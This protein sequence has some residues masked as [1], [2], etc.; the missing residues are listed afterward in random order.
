MGVFRNRAYIVLTA[1]AAVAGSQLVALTPASASPSP[2]SGVTFD[3]V[4]ASAPVLAHYTVNQRATTS[5]TRAVSGSRSATSDRALARATAAAKAALSRTHR[6]GARTGENAGDDPRETRRSSFIGMQSSKSICPYFGTGCN[7]PDMAI[8]A[9]PQ[10]VLQGVNSSFEV[11]DTRGH[12]QTGWPRNSQTFFGVPNEPNNCD[13]ASGNQPFMSDPRAFYDPAHKRFWAASLQVEGAIGVAVNCPLLTVY[14][15]AV[16]QTSDPRG[17]WNVYEFDMSAGT[18]NVADFTQFGFNGDAVYFSANMFTQDGTAYA[19]AE[20][21]EANKR[22]MENGSG[23]FTSSG[24]LSLTATGP[25][26]TYLAATVQPV[27]TLGSGSRGEYFVNT[28]DAPDPVNGHLCQ[29]AADTCSGL[30]LWQMID[31]I[32][33]DSGGPQPT[34]TGTYVPTRPYVFAPPADQPTCTQCIDASDLR[35]SD[36]PVYQNGTVHAAWETAIDNRTQTVPGIEYAQVNVAH[37]RA[38]Q[39]SYYRFGGDTAVSFPAVMPDGHGRVVM[40]YD[41]MSSTVNPQTRYVTTE[42]RSARFT[43]PGHLIKAGE[44]PYRPGVCGTA[45]LPVCRWGDYSAASSDGSGNVWLAGQYANGNVGP[46]TDPN[47]SSRNW[48]T[49]IIGL[50]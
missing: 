34:L 18:T 4:R 28:F 27:L 39:S 35:I 14:Y 7:P 47:F 33:H 44:A 23:A 46:S 45:V 3:A 29:N 10:W 11:L 32:A 5:T 1:A 48:G 40:V 15:L 49:W 50:R 24:F 42:S 22:M 17:V 30:G 43:G 12:V 38:S 41:L 6:A 20:L 25:G 36:T 8:A 26:A 13:P 2:T 9:S 19:Y 31:P 21:F 37:P 16:S